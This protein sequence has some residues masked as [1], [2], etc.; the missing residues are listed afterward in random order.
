MSNIAHYYFYAP[1]WDYP[2]GGPIKL[3]SVISTVKQPEIALYTAPPLTKADVISSEK[4]HVEFSREKLRAG[5]FS[6]L[7]Q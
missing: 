3:G 6:I 5:D 7:C 1:T 2:P 4:T